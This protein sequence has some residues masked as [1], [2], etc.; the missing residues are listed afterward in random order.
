MYIHHIYL[1]SLYMSLV[2]YLTYILI[3]DVILIVICT[4]IYVY[5][6]IPYQ[7]CDRLCPKAH[8]TDVTRSVTKV[9]KKNETVPNIKIHVPKIIGC[10]N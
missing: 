2:L 8:L 9:T 4:D 5:I 7:K 10:P 1:I 6:S 3:L